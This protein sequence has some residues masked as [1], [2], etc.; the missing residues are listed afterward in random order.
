MSPKLNPERAL[1]FR[2]THID[3]L[4]WILENGLHCASSLVKD[5]AFVSIGNPD[6][7][8]RRANR[9]LPPPHSGSLSDY[10][11]F[12]F[13][14]YSP[15][16]LNIKT[17][18]NGIT[19]RPNADI[20]VMVSSFHNLKNLGKHVVFSDRHA[21]LQ[22]AKFSADPADL[23]R[24]DWT[25][26]Q[27]R[28]FKRDAEDPEKVERYQAEALAFQHVPVSALLGIACYSDS[29]KTKVEQCATSLGATIKVIAQPGWYF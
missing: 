18:Y 10:V 26:L 4:K 29:I 22:A 8:N 2:I 3:N 23:S 12:Y 6:L 21:Y 14:P 27:N 11:P 28:D 20:A 17:G 7:I 24:I 1:I 25:L 16:M 9:N 13:T 19:R 5:P 15:M